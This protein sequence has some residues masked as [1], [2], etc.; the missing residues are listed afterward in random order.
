VTVEPDGRERS[1]AHSGTLDERATASVRVPE[2][3]VDNSSQTVLR[4]YPGAFGQ[5]VGGMDALLSK[6]TGC[7][8][9][10]SSSLYP[11]VLA[12][13]YM[14]QTG[15]TNPEVRMRAERF[16]ATGYQRILTF[17]T[18]TPGG[19]SLFGDNPPRPLL[20]AYGL[21]EM[22]DMNRV[23]EVDQR[24]ITDM[25]SY[26]RSEQRADGSWQ[27][28]RGLEY[29]L[30]V[31]GDEVTTTAYVT[32]SLAES[33]ADDQAVDDGASYVERNLD[34][35]TAST[36]QL[37]IALNALVAADRA[38]DLRERI[39]A[40]LDERAVVDDGSVHWERSD[41]DD[42]RGYRYGDKSVLTTAMVANGLVEGG[43][44]PGLTDGALSWLVEQKSGDGGWGSTQN[45]VMALKALVSA[46]TDQAEIQPGE[47]EVQRNG[48]TVATRTITAE[49]SDEVQT[50]VLPTEPGENDFELRGP[51]GDLY[52]ELETT[53]HEPWTE[54]RRGDEAID[55]EGEAPISMS[56]SYNRTNLTVDD[57]VA[58]TAN[59]TSR[60][61]TIGTALVSLGVPP[62]FTVEENFPQRLQ[63]RGLISRY[64]LRGRQ[65]ILYV[66]DL[67]GSVSLTYDVRATTPVEATTGSASVYDYYNPETEAV[68]APVTVHV[69]ASAE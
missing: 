62:G 26:L 37:A 55:G 47:I 65:V 12:L 38:P 3:A 23:Y 7:F 58:V 13:Q 56:V 51:E 9:Q 36:S 50:F 17:E 2:R 66:E 28:D 1:V 14:E 21:M 19:Y 30:G 22:A 31:S 15:E 42:D 63:D 44:A 29:P 54:E 24:T 33:G 32:W 4:T 20:T 34:V 53:Y 8:E 57:T 48:E 64:E 27:S 60:E 43:Y 59:V 10:T 49:N 18:D 5:V 35:E 40:E 41:G 16:I 45:T 52:Y 25:Q 69:N 39:V 61:G 67:R 68:D 46:Q 6:P 11:N